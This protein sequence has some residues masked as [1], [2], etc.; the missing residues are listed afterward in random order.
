MTKKIERRYAENEITTKEGV[1][2]GYGC[3][4]NATDTY[5][6]RFEKGCFA[7][8]IREWKAKKRN[9]PIYINHSGLD[10]V[11]GWSVFEEDDY[12]LKVSGD[13]ATSRRD[14]VREMFDMNV[15]TG[16]SIGFWPKAYRKEQD[17]SITYTDV[18]LVEVSLVTNPSVPGS[19][20]E[21]V[22]ADLVLQ[23][24]A[25]GVTTIREFEALLRDNGFSAN[26]AKGIAANGF[27]PKVGDA[28]ENEN[29]SDLREVADQSEALKRAL[30]DQLLLLRLHNGRPKHQ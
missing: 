3:A 13:L 2:E 5:G 16:M 20:I 22:R 14:Y 1:V 24:C 28:A 10:P 17:G 6:T 21:S 15:V 25:N 29:V 27:K 18:N 19:D 11:G 12:G 4:F 7:R 23:K 30:N 8:T 26:A 9:M